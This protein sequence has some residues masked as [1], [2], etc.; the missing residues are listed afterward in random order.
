MKHILKKSWEHNIN[1][2]Q[3]H[4]DFKQAYD[5]VYREK[6]YEIMYESGIPNKLTRLVRATMT[7]TEAQVKIQSQLIDPFIRWELKVI[8]WLHPYLT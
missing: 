7:D 3:I 2:Y 1:V 6:I 5:S 4:V 8:G